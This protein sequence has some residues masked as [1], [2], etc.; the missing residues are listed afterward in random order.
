M[1]CLRFSLFVFTSLISSNV[2]CCVFR[3]K[4]SSCLE[5]LVSE[6]HRVRLP[7]S[8]SNSDHALTQER[9]Y[10]VGIRANARRM[11]LQFSLRYGLRF[12]GVL[13]FAMYATLVGIG[14]VMNVQLVET[15]RSASVITYSA[16]LT[17]N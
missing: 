11:T 15:H 10:T 13:H 5:K 9:I 6:M 8:S 2:S 7:T 12:Q 16:V 4:N 3:S 1:A 17:P 14:N